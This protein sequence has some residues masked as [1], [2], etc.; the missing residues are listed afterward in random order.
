MLLIRKEDSF[1][2]AAITAV[3]VVHLILAAFI[4]AA[5]KD[6]KSAAIIK[7]KD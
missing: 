5:W 4:Y 6:A 2:Y 3:F 7:K 1:I